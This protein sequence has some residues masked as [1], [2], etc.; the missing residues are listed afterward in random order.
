MET[1]EK[2]PARITNGKFALGKLKD[3]GRGMLYYDVTRADEKSR[4]VFH[5]ML[6]Y[7][8]KPTR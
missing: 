6:Q 1:I 3:F 5:Y 2:E 8:L 4:T 7:D